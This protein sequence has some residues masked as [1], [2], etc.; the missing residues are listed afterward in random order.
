MIDFDYLAFL[1]YFSEFLE[2][3]NSPE[4]LKLESENLQK[5]PYRELFFLSNLPH[6]LMHVVITKM[7]FTYKKKTCSKIAFCQY[8]LPFTNFCPLSVAFWL[9]TYLLIC[10]CYLFSLIMHFLS[11]FSFFL[12][13]FIFNSLFCKFRLV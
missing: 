1:S 2:L 4:G 13:F 9:T 12:F 5:P 3:T 6:S 11:F 7:N 8:F 10:K